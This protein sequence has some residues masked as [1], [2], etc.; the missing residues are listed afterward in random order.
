MDRR[1]FESA[2]AQTK[3][4]LSCFELVH[5][6][7]HVALPPRFINKTKKGICEQ[8]DKELHLYST[9]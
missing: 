7:R 1:R 9:Q 8:L 4:P 6:K 5:T 2:L 3:D